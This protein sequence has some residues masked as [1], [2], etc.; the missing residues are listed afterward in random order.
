MLWP[1]FAFLGLVSSQWKNGDHYQYWPLYECISASR[2]N[3]RKLGLDKN[4][5]LEMDLLYQI[6]KSKVIVAIKKALPENQEY[7]TKYD[8]WLVVK[9]LR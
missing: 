4:K 7:K 9:M 6:K 2:K 8:T 5:G 1:C 3:L